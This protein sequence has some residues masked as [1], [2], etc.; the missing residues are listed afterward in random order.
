MDLCNRILFTAD[1]HLIRNCQFLNV[2]LCLRDRDRLAGN[3]IGD[4]RLRNRLFIRRFL[5]CIFWRI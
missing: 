4:S 3:L 5:P 1:R 2:L